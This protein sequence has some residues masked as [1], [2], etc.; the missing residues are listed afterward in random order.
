M[1]IWNASSLGIAMTTTLYGDV[2]F[3]DETDT[4]A[5]G[6]DLK[7]MGQST[8][9]NWTTTAQTGA[10]N[11]SNQNTCFTSVAMWSEAQKDYAYEGNTVAGGYTASSTG[12]LDYVTDEMNIS[13]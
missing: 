5:N 1:M 3:V 10:L 4:G 12:C 6:A 7:T 9:K 13:G 8:S 11:T 2:G